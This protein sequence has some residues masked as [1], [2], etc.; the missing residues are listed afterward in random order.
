MS[1]QKKGDKCLQYIQSHGYQPRDKVCVLH[2]RN[3]Q[4]YWVK[5][6]EIFDPHRLVNVPHGATVIEWEVI[7]GQLPIIKTGNWIFVKPTGIDIERI[8][9]I[10]EVSKSYL[11]NEVFV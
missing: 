5:G 3:G 4:T 7:Q 9:K 2:Y 1:Q 10:S 6:Y 8:K 11:F